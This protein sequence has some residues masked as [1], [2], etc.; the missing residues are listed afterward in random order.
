MSKET[1]EEKDDLGAVRILVGTL[2]NFKEEEQERIIRWTREKLGL[3]SSVQT[4]IIP[5]PLSLDT[6]PRQE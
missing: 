6:Y 5:Q 1:S 4:P 2:K 3:S